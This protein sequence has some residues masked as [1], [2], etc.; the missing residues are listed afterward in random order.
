MCLKYYPISVREDYYNLVKDLFDTI[1]SLMQMKDILKIAKIF[2]DY[3]NLN[4]KRRYLHS[5]DDMD[6]EEKQDIIDALNK[7]LKNY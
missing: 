5:W 3:H 2:S 1:E 6:S 7:A 4:A